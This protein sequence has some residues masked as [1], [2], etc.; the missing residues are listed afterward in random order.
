MSASTLPP[1]SLR[2]QQE[3]LMVCTLSQQRYCEKKVDLTMQYPE[4]EPISPEMERGTEGHAKLEEGALPITRE[5]MEAS[6]R[7]GERLILFEFPMEGVW[8]GIP[9]WGRPDLV[10]LEGSV[11]TLLVEFKFSRRSN[12]F[13][14]QQTQANL[15]GWLLQQNRFEVSALLCAVAILPAT[16]PPLKCLPTDLTKQIIDAT[17]KLRTKVFRSAVP[18]LRQE[19]SFTLHLFPFRPALAERDLKWSV[20]YWQGKREPELSGSINKCRI[21]RFNAEALCDQALSPFAG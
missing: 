1:N 13:P 5:E 21:C 17:E 6:L 2:H 14:S 18:I 4:V 16:L 3:I 9:I 20:S 19:P 7:R 11:A 10:Q 15:Y 8:E 12:L